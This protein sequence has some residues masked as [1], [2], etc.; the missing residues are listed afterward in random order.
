[1][2]VCL[3]VYIYIYIYIVHMFLCHSMWLQKKIKRLWYFCLKKR[4]I[5]TFSRLYPQ[6]HKYYTRTHT[7]TYNPLRLENF[8]IFSRPSSGKP[9]IK[10]NISK[11]Q[12]NQY[13]LT[14]HGIYSTYSPR[15]S[16]HFLARCSNLCKPLKKSEI[17]PSNQVSVSGV[18]SASDDKLR[19]FNCFF[20]PWNR[21]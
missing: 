5:V 16:I 3:C 4:M 9:Y 17:C 10:T 8:S 13:T 11:T 20:I 19:N 12:M 7:F 6:M 2:C 15:S 21:W 18:T 1:M 14:K